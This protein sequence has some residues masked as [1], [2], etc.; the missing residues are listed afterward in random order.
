MKSINVDNQTFEAVDLASRMTGM[1]HAEV[2]AGLIKQ[3]KEI[4]ATAS[5]PS[6]DPGEDTSVEVHADYEGHR[7]TARFNQLTKRIDIVGGP[8]DGKSF[9]SPSSAA[10]A[11]V[12]HYKPAVNPHR[13]GWAFWA[14]TETGELLQVLRKD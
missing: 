9:K 3:I 1:S 5:I 2:I 13:N 12:G 10:R 8:L 14:L 11:V 7:T 6:V 4:D